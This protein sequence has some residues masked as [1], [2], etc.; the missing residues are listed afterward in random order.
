MAHSPVG[1]KQA[2]APSTAHVG[3]TQQ[4][5]PPKGAADKNAAAEFLKS[6]SNDRPHEGSPKD[7]GGDKA[8]ADAATQTLPGS[9]LGQNAGTPAAKALAGADKSVGKSD[10]GT[11]QTKGQTSKA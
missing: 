8:R 1:L 5:T 4:Q 7:A 2:Q 6:M 3:K 9:K 10:Q 11:A